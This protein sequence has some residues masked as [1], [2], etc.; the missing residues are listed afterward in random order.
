MSGNYIFVLV[1]AGMWSLAFLYPTAKLKKNGKRLHMLLKISS[2]WWILG[3]TYYL[4][5]FLLPNFLVPRA[6]DTLLSLTVSLP[7][8]LGVG[9]ETV[10]SSALGLSRFD[11]AWAMLWSLPFSFVCSA[12]MLALQ[13]AFKRHSAIR[14]PSV[15]A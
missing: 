4:L 11:L 12:L 10:R 13:A 14:R 2:V 3:M 6:L 8:R 9:V 7:I 5:G 1:L 15:R